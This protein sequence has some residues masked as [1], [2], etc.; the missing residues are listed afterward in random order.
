MIAGIFH[1]A[2][3]KALPCE[4]ALALV[5]ETPIHPLYT[6]LPL[7]HMMDKTHPSILYKAS[8]TIDTPKYKDLLRHTVACCTYQLE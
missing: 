6:E 3:I 4:E 7:T 8:D 5:L 1:I 2:K